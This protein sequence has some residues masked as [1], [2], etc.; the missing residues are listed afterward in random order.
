M[1]TSTAVRAGG[2]TFLYALTLFTSASLVFVVEPM[3]GKLA[4]PLLGGTPAVWNT[5]MVFYQAVLLGGYAYAHVL[6]SRLRLELQVGLHASLLLIAALSLPVAMPPLWS[7]PVDRSPIPSL[8]LALAGGV[9][10]PLFVL[11]ATAPL[12]QKWFSLTDSRSAKDPY[13]L[14]AASNVGS[15]LALI[16]YPLIIEPSTSLRTQS[17]L[18]TRGYGLLVALTVACGLAARVRRQR[19]ADPPPALAADYVPISW[20]R[21]ARWLALSFVPSSLMLA[22]TTYL[23]TDVGSVPLL[24]TIPLALYLLSFILGF[25]AWRMVSPGM[26]R[27]A[28]STALVVLAFV[29]AI[30]IN[31]PLLVLLALH[32]SV[33]FLVALALHSDLAEDRPAPARLTEFYLWIAVGGVA[34]GLFNT[35]AAPLLFTGVV[36]YPLALAAAAWLM[37]RQRGLGRPQTRELAAAVIAGIA[38]VG[39][40]YL[41]R[42]QGVPPLA[43]APLLAVACMGLFVSARTTV[44]FGLAVSLVLTAGLVTR[45]ES[46]DLIYARRTFF[47]VLRVW[48]MPDEQQHRIAHGTTIHGVQSTE[49][50]RRQEPLS[51]YHAD[52]PIGQVFNALQPRLASARVAVVGLGAGGLAAYAQPQQRWTFYEIDPEVE[53]V[54]RDPRLFTFLRDCGVRCEVRLGD[55]RLGLTRDTARYDL[56]VLDAFSS[57]AIPVHLMTREAMALYLDRLADN[58]VLVFHISNR[59]LR[60]RSLVAGL[61]RERRLAVRGQFYRSGAKNMIRTSSEWVAMAR[62]AGDLGLL[63]S[64]RRWTSLEPEPGTRIWSDDFS[65]VL[66]V[67]RL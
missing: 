43:W 41:L 25:A 8:L 20:R 21:R 51:Y 45:L 35:L 40:V 54:A 14:Y 65:D 2:L 39:L 17:T 57:D 44:S 26:T 38:A 13:F 7:P 10:A 63:A 22:A 62:T 52:G 66:S 33:L 15:I 37:R 11:S 59:H 19:A 61:A 32:L 34:G 67:L 46:G 64:D 28:A 24:W 1:S 53:R 47:G 58:G 12:L 48:N 27:T 18:W 42:H 3:F 16:A 29:F 36:E 56:L 9:G 30:G 4:L 23:S 5:C 60:L 50:G 55:A 31:R 6:S 49:A